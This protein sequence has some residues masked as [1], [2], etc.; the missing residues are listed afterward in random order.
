LLLERWKQVKAGQGQVILLSGEGGIGKSRLVQEFKQQIAD[1]RHVRF[2]YRSSPYFQNSALYPVIGLWEQVFAVAETAAARFDSLEQFLQENVPATDEIGPPAPAQLSPGMPEDRYPP[3]AVSS[4]RQRQ[5]ALETIVATLLNQAQRHPILFS[6]EDL[7]WTDP[8]TIELLDLLI[9]RSSTTAFCL[10]LTCRPTFQPPWKLQKHLSPIALNRLSH[11]QIKRMAERVA[12]DKSLP[13]EVLQQI[14]DKTDGV[15]LFVEETTKA[16]VESDVLEEQ[17]RHYELAGAFSAPA[18]P[19]TLND[20]L[21]SRLDRLG[22]AK[23][24]A[25][26]GAVIGRDFSYE[27]FQAVAKT[28]EKTMGRELNKLVKAEILFQKGSPPGATYTFKHALIQD[29][30]YQSLLKSSRQQYHRDTAQVLE[31]QF[32]DRVESEPELLAH[33]HAKAG[34]PERA[35]DYWQKAGEK[36]IRRSANVEAISHLNNG[37][38]LFN[39][40]PDI[41]QYTRREIEL[42]TTLELVL[43]AVKGDAAQEVE[44]ICARK[45]MLRQR[46]RN[47]NDKC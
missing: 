40:L 28:D 13:A 21:M 24:I 2:E 14:V 16:V 19:A 15:P 7:Q 26:L 38:A 5:Q 23:D 45:H 47:E 27:V 11:S 6:L 18:I 3:G 42:L 4:Q 36:A 30:A 39:V 41:P 46:M 31:T 12:G 37:L 1:D 43:T 8:S 10:L 20:S 22:S 35:I 32:P 44:T 17:N 34:L 25:Q 9:D 29:A 33:H